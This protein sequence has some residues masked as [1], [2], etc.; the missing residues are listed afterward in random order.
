[1]PRRN[2]EKIRDRNLWNKSRRDFLKTAGKSSLILGAL[3]ITGG[4]VVMLTGGC[5]SSEPT[6]SN[7]Y[8]Y[9]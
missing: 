6:G 5:G 2:R 9:H 1:M 4:N 7:D 8:Q 3:V